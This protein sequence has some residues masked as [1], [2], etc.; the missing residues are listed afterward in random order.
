MA[1]KEDTPP[2]KSHGRIA[3]RP[4][5][6]P[7]ELMSD[8]P[9]LVTSWRAT[10]LT[11][12]PD[13]FPGVLGKSLTGKALDEGIWSLKTRNIRDYATG[14]HRNVDDTPAGGG[15]GMVLRADVLGRALDDTQ[16]GTPIVY[17]SP[18][19][20]PLTQKLAQDLSKGPGVTVLCGRFEGIDERILQNR[21]ILEVSIGDYVL[22]GGELAAQVLIDACVRLIPR[23]LGNLESSENE[24][25][26]NGLLEH[27]QFTR[28]TTW[29]GHDIP[30]ILLSGHHGRIAD[31][32]Q[33]Q[34]EALTKDRRPD[35]WRAYLDQQDADP[36]RD[37][38]L[39]DAPNK[40]AQ[41]DKKEDYD[42]H[43]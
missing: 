30:E 7:R 31:W 9:D 8:S 25:F 6:K 1:N 37:Q 42:E 4:S 35:L 19:G 28:P 36:V 3:V 38:E 20:R 39:S 5:V 27:P 14:K 11:L 43:D 34:S 41:A 24:S 29:E 12:Y 26:S 22:T 17:V 32:R 15:A 10:V 16:N 18:R 2:S 23:V 21:N 13:M 33:A 40:T